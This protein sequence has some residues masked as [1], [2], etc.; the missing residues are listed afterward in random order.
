MTFV[1]AVWLPRTKF[2]TLGTIGSYK[3]PAT[4]GKFKGAGVGPSPAY[5]YSASVAEVEVNPETGVVV[6]PRIWMAHDIGQCIN[7]VRR[8]GK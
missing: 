6:V 7:P 2:G 3:P 5:S 4:P 8:S 1:E